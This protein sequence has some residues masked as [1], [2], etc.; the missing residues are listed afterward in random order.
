MFM[1]LWMTLSFSYSLSPLLADQKA[2]I[3]LCQRWLLWKFYVMIIVSCFFL[4]KKEEEAQSLGLIKQFCN[5]EL[6]YIGIYVLYILSFYLA[7]DLDNFWVRLDCYGTA[8]LFRQNCTYTWIYLHIY[9]SSNL[10]FKWAFAVFWTRQLILF[11]FY[12][13]SQGMNVFFTLETITRLENI[14]QFTDLQNQVIKRFGNDASSI[15]CKM[16][17]LMWSLNWSNFD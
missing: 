11:F 1:L 13:F 8:V 2:A 6:L 7:F 14:L 10:N 15:L 5:N 16:V 12:G 4:R 3:Q 17:I 9:R